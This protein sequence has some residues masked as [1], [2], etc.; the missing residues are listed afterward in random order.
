MK[1][2]VSLSRLASLFLKPVALFSLHNQRPKQTMK[3][4]LLLSI[5]L[6]TTLTTAQ[7]LP[8]FLHPS[9]L[10]QNQNPHQ[11]QHPIMPV[12]PSPNVENPLPTSSPDTNPQ[13]LTDVLPKTR[14]INIFAG[15]TRD[16][17][18]ISNRLDDK[19][20]NTTLLCPLNSAVTALPRKPWEDPRDGVNAYEGEEGEERA[21]RN[22][23]R[24]VEE[25]VVP[26]SP[27]KEEEKVETV[28]GGQLWW[29]EKDGVRRIMPGNVEVEQV[30]GS[31]A[32]GEVWVLR[33]VVN[34]A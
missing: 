22:L 15:F 10:T 34:Y 12:L 26:Q 5:P 4:S 27:W 30:A 19:T 24:F 14:S 18:A 23:R 32:N 8:A 31:V 17:E 21:H 13:I 6:L 29:K 9:T 33:G 11:N 20:L 28:G 25:H 7:L 1:R 2:R 3:P 16:I